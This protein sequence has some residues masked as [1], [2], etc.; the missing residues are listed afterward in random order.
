MRIKSEIKPGRFLIAWI[1]AAVAH[2]PNSW[3]VQLV[4]V[5]ALALT[6]H[7]V[8]VMPPPQFGSDNVVAL[9]LGVIAAAAQALL[10]G[11]TMR[12]LLTHRRRGDKA[13]RSEFSKENRDSF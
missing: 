11:H 8:T 4:I 10:V 13:K 7:I 5:L 12:F 6:L 9:T 3:S 1:I 2:L